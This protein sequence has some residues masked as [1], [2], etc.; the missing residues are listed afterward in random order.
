MTDHP[1]D[2]LADTLRQDALSALEEPSSQLSEKIRQRLDQAYSEGRGESLSEAPAA[3][4][5]KNKRLLSLW[6]GAAAAL[7][8]AMTQLGNKPS[9]PPSPALVQARPTLLSPLAALAATIDQPLL[10]EWQ[11]LTQ[12]AS[13]TAHYLLTQVQ[14]PL[15]SFRFLAKST[16]ASETT[17][18]P[19]TPSQHI[20]NP[21]LQDG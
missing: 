8:I 3:R 19:L 7:F 14:L 18:S 17:Q 15:Q 9:P 21:A 5:T 1:K 12:D 13:G 4:V 2:S 10:A 20:G 6:L 16:E 11:N